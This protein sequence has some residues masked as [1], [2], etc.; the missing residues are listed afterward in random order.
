ML[1]YNVY[2]IMWHLKT[3][4]LLSVTAV[5]V[6]VYLHILSGITLAIIMERQY[7]HQC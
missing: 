4:K 5:P 2:N 6:V 3:V 1:K 7:L